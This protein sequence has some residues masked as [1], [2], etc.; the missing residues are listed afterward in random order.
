M[1]DITFQP[2]TEFV[3]N[4]DEIRNSEKGNNNSWS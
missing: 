2:A 3:G 4:Y 1:T